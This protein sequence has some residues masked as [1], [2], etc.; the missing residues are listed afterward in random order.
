MTLSKKLAR[1]AET[2][3]AKDE[4]WSSQAKLDFSVELEN[5]R[6]GSGMT[7]ADIA[8]KLGTSP[9]YISKVFRG[10]TNLTI[11]TMVKLSRA[12]GGKIRINV[13]DVDTDMHAWAK[14]VRTKSSLKPTNKVVKMP[15]AYLIA[16]YAKG[17]CEPEAA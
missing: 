4:F 6:R 7:Y 17:E 16:N 3:K 15:N 9:A 8:R 10:D 12:V 5:Q 2:A 11:D 13:I 1:F 14:A